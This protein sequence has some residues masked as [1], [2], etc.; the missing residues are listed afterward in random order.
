MIADVNRH[1]EE[2]AAL[3]EARDA[4]RWLATGDIARYLWFTSVGAF[5]PSAA[6]VGPLARSP[7]LVGEGAP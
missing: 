7:G 2:R 3:S 1:S 4:K 5:G 6:R